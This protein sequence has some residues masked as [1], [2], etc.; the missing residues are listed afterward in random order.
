MAEN[1]K[2]GCLS[3][4]LILFVLGLIGNSIDQCSNSSSDGNSMTRE[5]RTVHKI[6]WN[7]YDK[8][9]NY[10]LDNSLS[11]DYGSQTGYVS[12]DARF[13]YDF[14]AKT[15]EVTYSAL[16]YQATEVGSLSHFTMEDSCGF[17]DE[18]GYYPVSI[19]GKWQPNGSGG[20]DLIISLSED[21][22]LKVYIFGDGWKHWAEYRLES[23]NQVLNWMNEALAEVKKTK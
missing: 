10:C 19:Q 4:I 3:W 9:M 2:G 6:A 5:E 20:G 8:I 11:R 18:N 16:Q 12:G 21:N 22:T 1:G 14:S 13:K 7:A 23:E 17:K 15:I